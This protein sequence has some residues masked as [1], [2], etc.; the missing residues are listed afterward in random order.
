[1]RKAEAKVR[2]RRGRMKDHL[3][4]PEHN[5]T[6]RSYGHAR[7]TVDTATTTAIRIQ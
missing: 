2:R 7:M 3:I 5:K 1:M 4:P 6:S